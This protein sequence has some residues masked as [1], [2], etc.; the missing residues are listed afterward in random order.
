MRSDLQSTRQEFI[1]RNSYPPPSV[2]DKE[3]ARSLPGTSF[4]RNEV[5]YI[6][7]MW[8]SCPRPTLASLAL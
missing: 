6:P 2:F 5:D 1:P 4:Q 8:E 7:M 3:K